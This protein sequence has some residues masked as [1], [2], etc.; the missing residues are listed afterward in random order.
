M[1]IQTSLTQL[2]PALFSERILKSVKNSDDVIT[3]TRWLTFWTTLLL[4]SQLF[5]SYFRLSYCQ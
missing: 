4:C 5:S 3:K 1:S 2:L